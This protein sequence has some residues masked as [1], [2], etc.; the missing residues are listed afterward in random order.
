LNRPARGIN[1]RAC[2]DSVV[3]ITCKR[4]SNQRADYVASHWS[5]N[6]VGGKHDR[7]HAGRLIYR[8]A[9]RV[10]YP[11][12]DT[13]VGGDGFHGSHR[14]VFEGRHTRPVSIHTDVVSAGEIS[15]SDIGCSGWIVPDDSP[16]AVWL[17]HAEISDL[18]LE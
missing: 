14:A 13:R 12:R 16:L 15:D 18:Q 1:R 7:N 9:V 17:Q 6:L 2:Q 11:V 3:A 8:A 4:S 10:A 5:T